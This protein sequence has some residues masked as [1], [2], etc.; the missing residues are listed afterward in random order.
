MVFITEH[1]FFTRHAADLAF[2]GSSHR[3][4]HAARKD[5]TFAGTGPHPTRFHSAN[6]AALLSP[7]A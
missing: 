1:L 6:R 4:G 3:S 5:A 2:G 7:P